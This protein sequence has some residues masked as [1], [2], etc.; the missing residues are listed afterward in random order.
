MPGPYSPW[1]FNALTLPADL[2]ALIQRI[3]EFEHS[4]PANH[5]E[6]LAPSRRALLDLASIMARFDQAGLAEL[7]VSRSSIVDRA[8]AGRILPR[9]RGEYRRL[10]PLLEALADF[11]LRTKWPTCERHVRAMLGRAEFGFVSYWT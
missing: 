9:L 3:L 8:V 11:F 1:R 2:V 10:K 4:N 7:E 6:T 5:Y